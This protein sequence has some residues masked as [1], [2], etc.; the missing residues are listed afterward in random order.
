VIVAPSEGLIPP[1]SEFPDEPYIAAENYDDDAIR[2]WRL[3][4]FSLFF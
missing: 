2:R 3:R 1:E 4:D